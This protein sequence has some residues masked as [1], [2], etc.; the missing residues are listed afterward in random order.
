M[1]WNENK[2]AS[3]CFFTVALNSR[4]GVASTKNAEGKA[5]GLPESRLPEGELLLQV[6]VI[7]VLTQ[8]YPGIQVLQ[9]NVLKYSK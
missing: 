7:K 4:N 5:A 3:P 6:S 9:Y 1:K 2:P 8:L